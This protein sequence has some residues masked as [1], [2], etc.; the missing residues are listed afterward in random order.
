MTDGITPGSLHPTAP[1]DKARHRSWIE[2]GSETLNTIAGFYN[3]TDATT[4]EAKR[5]ALCGKFK[6]IEREIVGPYFAGAS[7]HMID[8]VWGTIFRYFNVFDRLADFGVLTGLAKVGTWRTVL[9]Q[10][11]SILNA[12][13]DGYPERLEQFLRNKTSYLSTF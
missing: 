8:G 5:T 3:A 9:A 4:F 1:L 10:R 7:F 11:P 13:P 2:F 12:P 6:R